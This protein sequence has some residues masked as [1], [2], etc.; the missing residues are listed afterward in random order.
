MRI[1][2][3]VHQFMPEF[4][5]GTE[6]VAFNLA[7]ALQRSG[8]YVTVLTCALGERSMWGV[9]ADD[10][11]WSTSVD[12]VPVYAFPFAHVL[13]PFGFLGA[14]NP[15]IEARV[16]GFLAT[17]KFDVVHVMH[18]MRM[19]DAIKVLTEFDLPYITTLTDFFPMCHRINLIRTTGEL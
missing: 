19:L 18:S 6:T 12:G 1:L 13:D 3:I 17:H 4:A 5:T 2:F 16:R 15:Q 11:L 8:H 14:G 9:H 10:E 7:K